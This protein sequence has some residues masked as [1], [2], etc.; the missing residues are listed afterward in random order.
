MVLL[1]AVFAAAALF[2]SRMPDPI[3]M[4]WNLH[5][6]VDRWAAKTPL[7]AA[8]IP[9]AAPGIAGCFFPGP[10]TFAFLLAPLAAAV[11]VPFVYAAVLFQRKQP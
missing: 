2:Y 10:V 6:E 1:A 11:V 5:G 7:S 9:L 3:P 4:H 8:A